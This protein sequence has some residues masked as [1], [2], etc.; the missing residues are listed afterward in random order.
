LDIG[1]AYKSWNTA[2]PLL[3]KAMSNIIQIAGNGK[4]PVSFGITGDRAIPFR[5]SVVIQ[6][7]SGCCSNNDTVI[8]RA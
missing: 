4:V 1:S 6:R 8:A 2:E 5:S 3:E 7:D